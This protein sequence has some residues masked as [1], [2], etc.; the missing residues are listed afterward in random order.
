MG[1]P[2][3]KSRMDRLFDRI[4]S[5]GFESLTLSERSAFALRWFYI[6]TNNGGLHQLFSNAF[7]RQGII[8]FSVF[9]DHFVRGHGVYHFGQYGA[10]L[11]KGSPNKAIFDGLIKQL[12]DDGSLAQFAAKNLGGDPS[13]VPVISVG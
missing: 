6:E 9:D 2:E 12:K 7:S 8:Y 13:K 10:I 1:E 4:E 11:P 5:H 3:K